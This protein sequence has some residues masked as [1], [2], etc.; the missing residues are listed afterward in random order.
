MSEE[1]YLFIAWDSG[2]ERRVVLVAKTKEVAEEIE[3]MYKKNGW[4][5]TEV[6][7]VHVYDKVCG[8]VGILV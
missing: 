3:K 8:S 1:V 7:F 4:E 2:D 6:R 5:H